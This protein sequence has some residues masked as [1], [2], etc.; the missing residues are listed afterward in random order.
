[1]N[2]QIIKDLIERIKEL[3]ERVSFLSRLE[4]INKSGTLENGKLVYA[5]AT[6][7]LATDSE[8][9]YDPTEN[10]L[11]IGSISST[12]Q[13]AVDRGTGTDGTAAFKGTTNI[14]HFNYDTAEHT[15]LRGGKS[16]SQVII[17]DLNSSVQIPVPVNM[18][19]GAAIAT[20]A[21]TA[22]T[23]VN[24]WVNY[25][26]G[27]NNAGYY[28]DSFGIVHIRGLIKSGT[29][30]SGTTLF[31]LP[32]GYRPTAEYII[33]CTSAGGYVEIR[34]DT[35]GNVKG[36]AGLNSIY[37]SLDGIHFKTS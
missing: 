14:S 33:A 37:T 3:E 5:D 25:G 16:T 2:E 24:S 11:R 21:W 34:V 30:S 20:E 29:T 35:S 12:A 17:G 15:Y 4:H 10:R 13:L 8:L 22:P 32:S 23:L 19:A 36:F 26:S 9:T 1:M 28:K 27:Y 6:G 7:A 31:T 18:S